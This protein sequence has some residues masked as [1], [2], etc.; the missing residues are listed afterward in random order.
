VAGDVD[1]DRGRGRFHQAAPAPVSHRFGELVDHDR[2]IARVG[3]KVCC[4]RVD[5][6]L[7]DGYD[8]S[9]RLGLHRLDPARLVTLALDAYLTA[10][11]VDVGDLEPEQLADPEA[12][13]REVETANQ[14]T[15]QFTASTTLVRAEERPLVTVPRPTG[16][17][18][19]T[20]I[21]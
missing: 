17:L 18:K 10:Q 21:S 7:A 15:T 13:S 5:D 8:L 9:R 20:G 2:A 12:R 1:V 19:L 6:H 16:L 4:E 11:E 14:G 3:R